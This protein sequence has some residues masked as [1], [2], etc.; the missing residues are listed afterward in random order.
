MVGSESVDGIG[1]RAGAE[2]ATLDAGVIFVV[3]ALVG[4]FGVEIDGAG[5]GGPGRRA[6]ICEVQRAT[7]EIADDGGVAA[8]RQVAA[9]GQRKSADGAGKCRRGW[10]VGQ[11]HIGDLFGG[12]GRAG[13]FDFVFS[14]SGVKE[15][16]AEAVGNGGIGERLR[17]RDV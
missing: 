15:I 1:L 13:D 14:R 4:G 7:G 2:R 10:I 5:A 17:E 12:D 16:V 11:N 9:E 3:Q 8:H 6:L